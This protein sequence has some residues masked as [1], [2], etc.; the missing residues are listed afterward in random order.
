MSKADL[1]H[2][3][4]KAPQS[5]LCEFA[6]CVIL[7]AQRMSPLTGRTAALDYWSERPQWAGCN[8]D[9]APTPRLPSVADRQRPRRLF[10]QGP[11]PSVDDPLEGSF[12]PEFG[13]VDGP[14]TCVIPV[15]HGARTNVQ[16]SGESLYGRQFK[17]C[18]TFRPTL[19]LP[20][21]A[22]LRSEPGTSPDRRDSRSGLFHRAGR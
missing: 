13:G 14:Q 10:R 22:L 4:R 7:Q 5:A 16:F 2:K 6:S 20:L 3:Q 1:R 11:S 9:E 17:F 21:P 18:R 8:C 15:V 12:W 19:L